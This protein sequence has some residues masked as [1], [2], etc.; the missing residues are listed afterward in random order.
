MTYIMTYLKQ[1]MI[2]NIFLPVSFGCP[3]FF[4]FFFNQHYSQLIKIE[5][6]DNQFK[7]K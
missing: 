1:K 3:Y 7:Y 2:F 6:I 5:V 4:L